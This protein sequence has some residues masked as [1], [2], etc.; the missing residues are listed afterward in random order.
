[1][2]PATQ[3]RDALAKG[4]ECRQLRADLQRLLQAEE[5]TGADVLRDEIPWWLA[6]VHLGTFLRWVR[7]L[8]ERT[9]ESIAA[10]AEVSESRELGLAST[11]QLLAVA[12]LLE[13]RD[14]ARQVGR[15]RREIAERRERAAVA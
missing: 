13:D 12:Q 3:S 4:T 5:A 8:H 9:V 6:K 2:N 15:T 10:E 14:V 7:Y 1:V 11:R